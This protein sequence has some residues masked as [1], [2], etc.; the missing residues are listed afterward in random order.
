M[1]ALL[2]LLIVGADLDTTTVERVQV[3]VREEL[4]TRMDTVESTVHWKRPDGKYYVRLTD[5]RGIEYTRAEEIE[6]FEK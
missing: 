2:A 1:N 5:G 6:C 4:I 3:E